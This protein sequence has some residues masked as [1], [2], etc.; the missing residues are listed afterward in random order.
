MLRCAQHDS[1]GPQDDSEGGAQHD[2][3]VLWAFAKA[4][5]KLARLH[6]DY[7]TLEP[8]PLKFVETSV[9]APLDACP[10]LAGSSENRP[11]V[12]D[13]RYST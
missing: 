10:A 13:R 2:R 11:P 6:V 3:A 4:G 7:E 8:H 9:V 5:K 1:E 12:T